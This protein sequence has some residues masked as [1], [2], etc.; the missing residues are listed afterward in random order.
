MKSGTANLI[1][2]KR[3]AQILSIILSAVLAWP[4][5][6]PV[7]VAEPLS[8]IPPNATRKVGQSGACVH[9]RPRKAFLDEAGWSDLADDFENSDGRD[10][11]PSI[12]MAF[13]LFPLDLPSLVPSTHEYRPPVSVDDWTFFW[14]S[15]P[16][17]C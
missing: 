9:H 4:S 13:S 3:S 10:E 16:L 8:S 7:L 2:R 5:C 11:F 6:V 15:P 12:P 17:R 1:A 14:R